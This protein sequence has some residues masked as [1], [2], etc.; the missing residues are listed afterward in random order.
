[1]LAFVLTGQF[2]QPLQRLAATPFNFLQSYVL[3]GGGSGPGRAGLTLALYMFQQGFGQYEIGYGAA[4]A[5]L[6]FAVVLAF[7]AVQFRL[8]STR[9]E[10]R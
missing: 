5:Y 3:F 6:L 4:V 9:E 8:L 7:T 10:G 1:M 2:F